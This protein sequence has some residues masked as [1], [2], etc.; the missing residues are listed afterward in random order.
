[1]ALIKTAYDLSGGD[2]RSDV[3]TGGTYLHVQAFLTTVSGQVSYFIEKRNSSS[4]DWIPVKDPKDGRP[5]VFHTNGT[6]E[7]GESVAL[8]GGDI[9]YSVSIKPGSS[10]T[11]TLN[12]DAVTDGT[13]S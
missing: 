9:E 2:T 6:N 5:I 12:L 8:A 1:M 3:I 13:T 4:G 11:G 7:S 10:T